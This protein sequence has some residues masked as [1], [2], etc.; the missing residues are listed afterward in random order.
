MMKPPAGHDEAA[1]R[2]DQPPAAMINRRPPMMKP[3]A[4][5]DQP[6]AAMISR[7]AAHDQPPGRR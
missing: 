6:P 7:P 3:P 2:H 5:H 4:A 1:G